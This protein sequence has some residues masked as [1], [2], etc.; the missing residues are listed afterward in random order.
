MITD[1]ELVY[2][3][4]VKLVYTA[5]GIQQTIGFIHLIEGVELK[6]EF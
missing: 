5:K 6:I 4:L 2:K 3:Q 1:I